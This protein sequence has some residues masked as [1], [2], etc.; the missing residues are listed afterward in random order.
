MV[1]QVSRIGN[2][3]VLCRVRPGFAMVTNRAPGAIVEAADQVVRQGPD[4]DDRGQGELCRKGG[5]GKDAYPFILIIPGDHRL[6]FGGEEP[7]A[8]CG[9]RLRIPTVDDNLVSRPIGLGWPPVPGFRRA[10]IPGRPQFS[11]ARAVSFDQSCP[12][13]AIHMFPFSL[14]DAFTVKG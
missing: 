10:R 5:V 9:E 2:Q 7:D 8:R 4:G 1:M 3:P 12:R 11:G 6:R 13:L 14:L